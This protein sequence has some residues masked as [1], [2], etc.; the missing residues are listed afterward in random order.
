M[1]LDVILFHFMSF[2]QRAH[3]HISGQT[4]DHTHFLCPTTVLFSVVHSCHIILHFPVIGLMDV[5]VELRTA[6]PRPITFKAFCDLMKNLKLD[7]NV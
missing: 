5:K 1:R 2:T 7:L 3:P 4:Q 6:G